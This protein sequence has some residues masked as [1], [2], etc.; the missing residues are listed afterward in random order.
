MG[1]VKL[2]E[3]AGHNEIFRS[4]FETS[5]SLGAFGLSTEES[6]EQNASKIGKLVETIRRDVKQLGL[7]CAAS[8]KEKLI[9]VLVINQQLNIIDPPLIEQPEPTVEPRSIKSILKP[10]CMPQRVKQKR[11]LNLK[12]SYGVVTAK[13]VVDSL[14]EREAAERQ[15]ESERELDEIAKHER[16]NEIRSI[17][18]QLKDVR[19]RLSTVRSENMAVTKEI[20]QKKKTKT[21]EANEYA[22]QEAAKHEMES[23]MNEYS[24]ELRTLRGKLKDLRSIHVATNK[25]VMLKRKN[26]DQKKKEVGNNVQPAVQPSELYDS[27]MDAESL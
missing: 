23:L 1:S 9:N 3:L 13:E 8:D 24:D 26:F 17:D 2:S 12:V 6:R 14:I 4:S 19:N 16:E 15:Q 11:N 25:A 7:L 20:A 21:V 27:Q 22:L 10:P 5:F 18:G